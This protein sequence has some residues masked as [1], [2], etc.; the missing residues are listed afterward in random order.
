M[1]QNSARR[2]FLFFVAAAFGV[3]LCGC[4]GYHL[5]PSNGLAAGEK[6][7]QVNPFANQT[8]EPRLGDAVTTEL[9]RS[10]QHDGT[11]RLATH[12]GAD[13]VV[14]GTITLYNRHELSLV[15]KDVLTV[16]DYRV[17]V[18]AQVTARDVGTGKV[19]FEKPVTG[20]TL[21]QV[22]SDLTSSERQAIP[23]LAEALAKNVTALLVDGSW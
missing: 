10:L 23:L 7:V 22:G 11:Y 15:P 4:A 1:E 20:Y 9:R 17:T 3:A 19:I 18:T 5:G 13:I 21:I 12:G 8:M 14:S 16:S 2:R 6:S